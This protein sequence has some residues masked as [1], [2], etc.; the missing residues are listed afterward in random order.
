MHK[1]DTI[2]LRAPQEIAGTSKSHQLRERGVLMD[3]RIVRPMGHDRIN[4]CGK[5]ALGARV[6]FGE[7]P[8]THG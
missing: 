7:K 6:P 5:A 4:R 3:G 8:Y 2:G 1:V